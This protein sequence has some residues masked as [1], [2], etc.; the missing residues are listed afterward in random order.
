MKATSKPKTKPKP[1]IPAKFD[2]K[3]DQP[4]APKLEIV[5]VSQQEEIAL[6]Q[7]YT[8]EE[9]KLIKDTVA[10]GT[11][12]TEFLFF[13]YVAK[14]RRLDPLLR[15]IHCVKRKTKARD[16]NGE[17][18]KINGQQQYEETM[19]IQTA[20]DGYRLIADRT[21][22]YAPSEKQPLYEGVGTAD[23]RCTVWVKKY[24][25]GEWHE[26]PATTYFSEY[27]Q[28]YV[29]W[30]NGKPQYKP[31]SM[32]SKMPRNQLAKTAEA[33]ALRKA[34][35]EAL[36]GIYVNEELEHLDSTDAKPRK[37]T[38][39]IP[40]PREPA[41]V[42]A[43]ESQPQESKP[44]ESKPEPEENLDA[45]PLELP[46]AKITASAEPNRGHGQEGT[47]EDQRQPGM[48]RPQ[49]KAMMEALLLDLWP[50]Q[51]IHR[52]YRKIVGKELF[53]AEVKADIDRLP[54][55]KLALGVQALAIF[56][57]RIRKA[58]L[59]MPVNEDSL[60]SELFNAMR[61]AEERMQEQKAEVEA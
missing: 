6:Q 14:H 43:S 58:G 8:P 37:E 29:E 1:V 23:F 19:T 5:K 34:F 22:N 56:Q 57:S 27:V 12:D 47:Q 2:K 9:L 18:V 55:E 21:R 26:V 41:K 10:R 13:M 16:E 3:P 49:L 60:C 53:S 42:L 52:A 48:T 15:Q 36:S 30:V 35:P 46:Q 33:L 7:R 51:T 17:L 45:E 44:Q 20:I 31:N 39:S 50:N 11:T 54:I 40:P 24:S 28:T 61:E 4:S 59:P 25:H 32:W 38:G